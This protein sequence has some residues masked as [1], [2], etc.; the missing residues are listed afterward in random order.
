LTNDTVH[1]YTYD[2]ENRLTQV[3]GGTTATYIYSA[4]GLRRQKTVGSATLT[5]LYNLSGKV[6]AEDNGTSWGPGYVYLG[7]QLLAL[8][9]GGT[10]YFVHA[11]HL[12]SSRVLTAMNKSVYDKPDYLPY[13]EQIAGDTGTSHKFTGYP[14]DADTGLDYA[15]A[16][17]YGSRLGRFLTPDP[18]GMGAA[19]AT[20]PQSLNQYV[21][22]GDNPTN[23]TDPEGTDWGDGGGWGLGGGGCD[24]DPSCFGVSIPSPI[25][26]PDPFGIKNFPMP[27]MGCDWGC[28]P[29]GPSC[30]GQEDSSV[31]SAG[32]PK[33]GGRPENLAQGTDKK[34]WGPFQRGFNAAKDAL[35]RKSCGDFFGAQGPATMDATQY[36]FVNGLDSETGAQTVNPNFVQI[37]ADGPYMNYRPTPGQEGPFGVNWL[38]QA[39]FDSFILLHEL[40]HQLSPITDFQPDSGKGNPLNAAQSREVINACF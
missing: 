3:D 2:A 32:D 26:L 27:G 37:N 19:D 7:S 38:T 14:R 8:Y 10:T 15:S 9:T 11:D 5:Y 12:G 30:Y 36:H 6:V 17:Y 35:K 24:W 31:T 4:D 23:V 25:S 16:R 18:L 33:G 22:V 39:R 28:I 34:Y 40:G 1:S 21:Y 29:C 20:N 13:G